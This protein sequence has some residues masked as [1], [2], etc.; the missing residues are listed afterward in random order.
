ML[1]DV[2]TKDYLGGAQLWVLEEMAIACLLPGSGILTLSLILSRLRVVVMLC[3]LPC[4]LAAASF[5]TPCSFSLSLFTRLSIILVGT[6]PQLLYL[7]EL[8]ASAM[9]VVRTIINFTFL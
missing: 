2:L 7:N 4:L 3:S 1:K 5:S 8:F 6:F 9:S